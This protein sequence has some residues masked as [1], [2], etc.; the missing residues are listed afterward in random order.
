MMYSKRSK[1]KGCF[2]IRI[3]NH[4]RLLPIMA[5]L[6]LPL[7]VMAASLDAMV[8]NDNISMGE[9][10]RL[11]L[12]LNGQASSNSSPDISVLKKDFKIE[13]E[14]RAS[15]VSVINGQMT[16]STSWT[17]TLTPNHSGDLVIPPVTIDTDNGGLTSSAINIHVG[18]ASS[19]PAKTETGNIF[20]VDEVSNKNP[21]VGE[22]I[23][24]TIKVVNNRSIL[25]T[26]LATPEIKG[27]LFERLGEGKTTQEI[28]N[29]K[30]QQVTEI[31]YLVTP[32]DAGQLEIPPSVVSGKMELDQQQQPGTQQGNFFDPFGMNRNFFQGFSFPEYEPFNISSQKIIVNVKP[33]PVK[34]DPWLPV[35]SLKIIEEFD[36]SQKAKTGEPLTRKLRIEAYGVGGTQLPDLE[37]MQNHDDFRVYADKPETGRE[38]KSQKIYGWRSESFTLIPTHGG[39]LVMPEIKIPWWDIKNNKIA[40]STIPE[41]EVEVTPGANEQVQQPNNNQ[42]A[43]PTASASSN[44]EPKNNLADKEKNTQSAI[45]MIQDN[46]KIIAGI[47]F[48]FFALSSLILWG[49][50]LNRNKNVEPLKAKDDAKADKK[51]KI[52][53]PKLKELEQIDDINTIK[54]FLV[55]YSHLHWDLPKNAA[56]DTLAYAF[57]KYNPGID[58]E[59]I[60]ELFNS[61]DGALYAG[62]P[63]NIADWKQN[64][65]D[66]TKDI[67]QTKTRD[68]IKSVFNELNPK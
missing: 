25:E 22:S 34:M 53:L 3:I 43:K 52:K 9:N 30:M 56:M 57:V 65:A 46:W 6:L 8:D 27:V 40:Y 18:E 7:Q 59:S 47:L 61:L 63:I 68:G 36:N 45:K 49:S 42:A 64:F 44:P 50:N 16:S 55:N 54:E 29:G 5:M 48:G 4:I 13:S 24:Y 26:N 21:Y 10:I 60:Q 66:I 14:G 32:V 28:V 58:S 39:K 2:C 20:V 41:R 62:K 37:P 19:L 17:L 38:I 1:S 51:E 11:E 35:I 23:I 67:K 15:N 31:K 12:R 33:Q